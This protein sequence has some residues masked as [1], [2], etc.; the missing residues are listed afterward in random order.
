MTNNA[1]TQ[2]E[3]LQSLVNPGVVPGKTYF[4]PGQ[5]I[6]DNYTMRQESYSIFGQV[7]YKFTD[8]LTATVG[9]AYLHDR[10]AAVSNVV[11]QDPFS[12]LNLQN[13]PE[14]G[15]L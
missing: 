9:G 8:R 3:T 5:G 1:V 15:F 10:K 14:L 12:S 13:V 6:S 7:D 4:Q 2:L 11:L